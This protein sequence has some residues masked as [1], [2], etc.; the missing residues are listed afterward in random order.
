M[1]PRPPLTHF[2]CIPLVTPTSRPQLQTSL[3]RFAADVLQPGPNGE[4]KIPPRAIR[5]VGALHFTIGV[6]SLQ[7]PERVE[8]ACTFLKALDV[9]ELL[10]GAAS[11]RPHVGSTSASIHPQPEAPSTSPNQPSPSPLPR[12]LHLPASQ[13][14]KPLIVA[15]TGLS[16]MQSP[17]S[18]SI[19]YA[20]PT[21]LYPILPFAQRL[22]DAFLTAGFLLPPP[23]DRPLKLHVT[24]VNTIYVK[25]KA[26]GRKSSMKVDARE[27]IDCWGEMT[28]AEDVRVEKVAVCEMSARKVRDEEGEVV[29]E[30][31]YEIVSVELP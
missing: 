19:L 26:G 11:E 29:D 6:M 5:S 8:Q 22:H 15:L 3:P 4:P 10:R 9:G 25:K 2:L 28:W 7:T 31:Y 27:L 24:L 13:D 21:P 23:A 1:P 30:I 17:M 16:P 18:T 14:A 12:D 20:S